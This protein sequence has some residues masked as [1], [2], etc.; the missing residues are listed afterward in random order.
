MVQVFIAIIVAT[1]RGSASG[2][3][4][5][6]HNMYNIREIGGN[7]MSPGRQNMH[8]GNAIF[9]PLRSKQVYEDRHHECCHSRENLSRSH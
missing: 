7:V 1:C 5:N 4:Y 8:I 9:G 6:I 2:L 3:R